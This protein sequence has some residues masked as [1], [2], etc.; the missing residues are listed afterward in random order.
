M[1]AGPIR[2]AAVTWRVVARILLRQGKLLYAGRAGTGMDEAELKRLLGKFRPLE[3]KKMPS[4]CRRRATIASA[5]RSN[6]QWCI[7]CGPSLWPRSYLT[8]TADRLLRQVVYLG[9]RDDKPAKEVPHP[10]P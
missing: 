6:Y 3:I 8:W 7:G 1:S 5:H 2:R 10:E 4:R 9:L